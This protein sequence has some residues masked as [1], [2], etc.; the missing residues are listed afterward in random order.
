MATKLRLSSLFP[1]IALALLLAADSHQRPTLLHAS[2]VDRASRLLQSSTAGYTI[3]PHP[4]VKKNCDDQGIAAGSLSLT[5]AQRDAEQAKFAGKDHPLVDTVK[6]SSS[7]IDYG[8]LINKSIGGPLGAA[9]VFFVF[10]LLTLPFLFFWSLCECCCKR[11]CCMK[12]P[13]PGAPRSKARIICWIVGAVIAVATVG[14][15][16]GWVVTL[17]QLTGAAKDIKCGMTIFY[18]DIVRGTTLENGKMFAGTTGLA[19]LLTD[20][21]SFIDKVPLIKAD[22]QAV[23][24]LNLNTMGSSLVTKYDSFKTS[25]TTAPYGYKGSKTPATTV[26]PNVATTIK[27]AIDGGAFKSEVDTLNK[28]A[29]EIH[30]A[31][32]SIAGYSTSSLNSVRNNLNSMKTTLSS[33]LEKPITDMYNSIAGNGSQDY[34]ASLSSAMKTFMIVSIIVIVLFTST[35]LVILYFTAK[36]NKLHGL[37]VISKI[38]MLLQLLLGTFILIFAIFGS[39]IAIVFIVAC[40]V[41]D[42]LITT[43]DFLSKVSSDKSLSDIMSNCVHRTATG[44]LLK[45]LGADLSEMDKLNDIS[46]GMKAFEGIQANLTGQSSPYVGG[47]IS[48]DLTDFLAFTRVGRGTP[49]AEDV[50]S[51][52]EYFNTL[53]CR[54]DII[55]PLTVPAG[56]LASAP[57]DNK[58]TGEAVQYCITFGNLPGNGGL[59]YTAAGGRYTAPCSGAGTLSAANG[60]VA[61]QNVYASIHDYKT[62]HTSL[63]TFYDTNFYTDE[64]ALFTALKTSEPQLKKI[65]ENLAG[66]SATLNSLNGTF[67]EVV[68]CTVIRKEIIVVENVLCFRTANTFITQ[69]NLAVAVGAL[70]Y[71][72][73]WFIC[74]GIRLAT[75]RDQPNQSAVGPEGFNKIGDNSVS[76]NGPDGS[77][78][79]S[80]PQVKNTSFVNSSKYA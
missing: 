33:S 24:D 64:A 66:V 35:Y 42:G 28:A 51:G 3:T 80:V 43:P 29:S 68:D 2:V 4:D 54:Q 48:K 32:S 15:V 16:I 57:A 13:E 65:N 8:A 9:G 71:V 47:A 20:Y 59:D 17:G 21:I 39:I 10:S 19:D 56:Y 5:L 26:V 36:L 72:Y 41:L 75:K 40:A 37:K 49:E 27:G 11:T 77:Q 74:C 76:P 46:T 62:K 12:E 78:A 60:N 31:V 45:A 63:K 50:Q 22:A 52:Y 7:S 38:I 18:S 6:G 44:D 61:L 67:K 73:S 1:T 34:G 53:Q 79:Q 55:A 14:V 30:V 25:F 23:K 58:D 69:N 70:I